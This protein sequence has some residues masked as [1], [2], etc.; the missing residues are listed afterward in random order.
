MRDRVWF[1]YSRFGNLSDYVYSLKNV[2]KTS[3]KGGPEV[4]LLSLGESLPMR[5]L[6]VR[7]WTTQKM[8]TAMG[9]PHHLIQ[10]NPGW[11]SSISTQQHMKVF[12]MTWVLFVGG[13]YVCF[14]RLIC[15]TDPLLAQCPSVSNL[16][17]SCSG[18][19]CCDGLIC[20]E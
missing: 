5:R 3:T 10:P 15:M 12:Q 6:H 4:Q 13:G 18:L 1:C 17:L 2:T 16:G 14:A 19:P 7:M 20:L 9:K 11:P 8:R